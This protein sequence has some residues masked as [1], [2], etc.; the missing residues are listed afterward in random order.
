MKDEIIISQAQIESR[1]FTIR[2]EQIMLDSDLAGMYQVEIK[3]LNEQIKRNSERFPENF[4]FQLSKDEWDNL[5]SQFATSSTKHGG[6]RYLPFVFTEQGVAM[7]SAVLRSDVAVKVSIQIINAFVQ[8]RRLIGQETIQQLRLSNIEN[9]LVEHDQKFNQ[10]FNALEK[11]EL[12]QKGIFFDGQ[13]FDAYHFVADLVRKA[14]S[15]IILID[16]YLDDSVFT[17]LHKRK[18]EV[19][20]TCYTKSISKSL[21]LDLQKHN[22]Q[23]P[24]IA[25]KEL[26][27]AHD[28]FLIIDEKELYHLGASLKDLGKKWFAFSKMND[29]LEE[30]LLKLK[31]D[32]L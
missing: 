16:N 30:L 7:L 20:C 18:K 31:K 12:P 17:L 14:N 13:V 9:K 3:R 27:T 2:G 10:L 25:L 32:K 8:M 5:R 1:I 28:R 6:R 22:Q 19:S 26:K 23:Y 15:S 21:N 4:M 29:L 24:E 11:N